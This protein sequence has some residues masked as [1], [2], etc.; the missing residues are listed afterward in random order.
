LFSFF[1]LAYAA[2]LASHALTVG[3]PGETWL[4][5]VILIPF[6]VFGGLAGRPLGDR[7]GASGFDALAISLLGAAGLYTLAA[8]AGAAAR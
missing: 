5:A 4:S 2:T 8:V 3:I 1:A 6:A 7:L